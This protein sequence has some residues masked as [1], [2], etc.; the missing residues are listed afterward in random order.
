MQNVANYKCP[1]FLEDGLPDIA[2][3]VHFVQPDCS[4][5]PSSLEDPDYIPI[6]AVDGV[7]LLEN[8]L[9]LNS[10]GV[11]EHQPF[12]QDGIDFRMI[13]EAPTGIEDAPWRMV[14]IID[15]KAQV[16]SVTYSGVASAENLAGL[17]QTDPA[18]GR[19]LVLGFSSYDD[20][21][22]PRVFKWEEILL[23][24]NYGTH[25]RSLVSGKETAGTWVCEPSCFVDARWFGLQ[26]TGTHANPEECADI[27]TACGNAY[28]NMSIYMPSGY[29]KLASSLNIT[30][31]I[32]DRYVEFYPADSSVSVIV[33]NLE[34][35]GGHFNA[36]NVADTSSPRV[37]LVLTEGTL[38][39]SWLNGTINE[40]LYGAL[41][42][43][44]D[45]FFDSVNNQGS[46]SVTISK[47]FVKVADGV[48]INNNIKFSDC[49]L[50]YMES[51]IFRS[52]E[53][54]IS[55]INKTFSIDV[56][57]ISIDNFSHSAQYDASG[58]SITD[59]IDTTNFSLSE[60][61][62]S[63]TQGSSELTYS[64]LNFVASGKNVSLSENGLSV[65][66]DADTTQISASGIN[67]PEVDADELSA[68]IKF[69]GASLL[70]TYFVIQSTSQGAG[71]NIEDW[72]VADGFD[73]EVG[74]LYAFYH[75]INST[76][77]VPSFNTAD[78]L[79]VR[80]LGP[81]ET[82]MLL[83]VDIVSDHAVFSPIFIRDMIP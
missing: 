48:T 38:K 9:P 59:G 2:G 66:E 67:T 12:V 11:F 73:I 83:C 41:T 40:F 24:D 8:P 78:G 22:P 53:F 36:A 79:K 33:R 18:V 57:K 32:M 61:S 20:S 77:N 4:A 7:T 44:N 34:N 21:C 1:F 47:K 56:D 52:T 37:K 15:S 81:Y 72:F 29:Y 16:Y 35:R 60:L 5:A 51:G 31:L 50:F 27:I 23:S 54:R 82:L 45:I 28:P 46:T 42:Y 80:S 3:R 70:K 68:H 69:K 76:S 49:F 63:G 17:R 64:H 26:R 74:G 13:V 58:V 39:T 6:Y 43:V 10:E 62:F 25:I 55:A 65:S 14:C 75:D 30:G 19:C 71:S